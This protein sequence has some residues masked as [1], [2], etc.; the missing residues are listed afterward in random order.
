V[1]RP[2]RTITSIKGLRVLVTSVMNALPMM[3]QTVLVLFFFFLIFAI[4]G[5]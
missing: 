4:A 5:V 1:L 3:K 2:L